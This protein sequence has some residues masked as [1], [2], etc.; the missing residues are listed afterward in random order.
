MINVWT[1]KDLFHDVVTVIL[2]SPMAARELD[3][4]DNDK[5]LVK[6]ITLS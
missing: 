3:D 4:D 2:M 1:Q 5:T 6:F